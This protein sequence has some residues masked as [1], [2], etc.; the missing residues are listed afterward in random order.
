MAR[1]PLIVRLGIMTVALFGVL[2]TWNEFL[3]ALYVIDLRVYQTIRWVRRRWLR[4]GRSTGTSPP[5]GI[6]TLVPILDLLAAAL[7]RAR[8]RRRSRE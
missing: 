2:F 8:P 7:H 3:V 5:V 6:V 1:H 4:S